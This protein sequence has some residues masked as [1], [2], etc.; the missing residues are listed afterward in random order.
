M[1][2]ASVHKEPGQVTGIIWR[3][4]TDLQTYAALKSYAAA[5]GQS[6]A[7][8]AKQLIHLSLANQLNK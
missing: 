1:T 4:P 8:A 7:A 6:V 5:T 2:Q 3:G